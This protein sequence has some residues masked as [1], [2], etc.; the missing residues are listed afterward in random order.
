ML[1]SSVA[2]AQRP[3]DADREIVDLASLVVASERIEVYQ[4]GME[5]HRSLLELAER[6]CQRLESLLGWPYDAASLGPRIRIYVAD[7]P[8]PSHV[9]RGYGHRLDPRAIVFINQRAYAGAMRGN[10]ATYIHELAH[11]YT[12]RYASHTLRE[13]IAD[14]LALQILPGAA[15][16]PH[17]GD[18]DASPIEARVVEYLGTTRPPPPQV[19]SDEKFRRMY[20]LASY[21]FV[22]YL[23]GRGGME[24]FLK[25]YDS[26]DPEAEF[27]KLYG[28]TRAELVALARM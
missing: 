15:V 22:K 6:A 12:W 3:T 20:Y 18:R 14:Y 13:G 1:A 26:P 2:L 8:G 24:T 17:G 9:W 11:L 27:A 5:I 10:N 7:F 4:Y 19:L 21:R 25:L 16:G 23:V 28:A